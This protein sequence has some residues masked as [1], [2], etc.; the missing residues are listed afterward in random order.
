MS[1]P[2]SPVDARIYQARSLTRF[3]DVQIAT[4]EQTALPQVA[5]AKRKRYQYE[6]VKRTLDIGIS[7]VA[8]VTFLSWFVP[9]ISI[10]IRL[11]SKGSPIFVQ[12]RVGRNGNHFTCIKLRTMTLFRKDRSQKITRIGRFLRI[13]KLDECLQFLNVLWG[14]MSVVGPRPHMISDHVLFSRIMCENYHQR[15]D[16]LPGITGLAQ[17]RGYAGIVDAKH[18]LRGR[19][20][21]DLFYIEKWSLGLDL[22]I[23]LNTFFFLVN[24][25]RI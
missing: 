17:V 24:P 14:Q 9:I 4:T 7:I 5:L 23:M 20:R 13:H 25:S 6:I 1:V 2:R 3:M 8:I 11:E 19:A 22:W 16:V 18:K 21:L 15:H 12:R 10:L